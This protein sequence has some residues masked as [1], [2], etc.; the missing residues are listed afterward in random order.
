MVERSLPFYW[1]PSRG[2]F[3]RDSEG[4]TKTPETKNSRKLESGELR[5]WVLEF[6]AKS[7]VNPD[8]YTL[9]ELLDM[10]Q[11]R[12]EEIQVGWACSAQNPDLLPEKYRKQSSGTK[13]AKASIKAV[14]E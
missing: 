10:I 11:A 8:P 14:F 9:G 4:S 3:E 5:Q 12:E 2:D 13:A 7:G 1:T 6:T